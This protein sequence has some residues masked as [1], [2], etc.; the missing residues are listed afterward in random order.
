MGIAGHS[1]MRKVKLR[2][3]AGSRSQGKF[4]A[5]TG[6]HAK[7]PPNGNALCSASRKLPLAR[8][9][10]DCSVQMLHPRQAS[11]SLLR[12]SS[13]NTA[14]FSGSPK[15]RRLRKMRPLLGKARDEKDRGECRKM[16]TAHLLG[17]EGGIISVFVLMLFVQ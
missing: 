5:E 14:E 9:H 2:K 6:L 16:E 10:S 3:N 1:W 12:R 13:G 15:P 7:A 11:R 8:D 17:K 4:P